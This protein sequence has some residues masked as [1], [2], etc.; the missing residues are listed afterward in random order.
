MTQNRPGTTA[1]ETT[2]SATL[3]HKPTTEISCEV[4]V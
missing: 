1:D 2:T 4:S 3:Q